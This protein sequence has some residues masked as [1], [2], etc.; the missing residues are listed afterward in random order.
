MWWQSSLCSHVMA[1]EP[2]IMN[3]IPHWIYII[4]YGEELWFVIPGFCQPA[5][6]LCYKE[7][8]QHRWSFVCLFHKVE[9]LACIL[10]Y[11]K[12][13]LVPFEALH[14]EPLGF[15]CTKSAIPHSSEASTSVILF[16]PCNRW[17]FS[18]HSLLLLILTPYPAHFSSITKI[19]LI[20]HNKG[21]R[22][23]RN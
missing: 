13:S 16:K 15:L 8:R 17:L 19:C 21:K 5:L 12:Q 18:L 2:V 14:K 22:Q 20:S 9:Y 4:S 10:K 3:P 7:H 23:K 11:F 1:Q 6:T